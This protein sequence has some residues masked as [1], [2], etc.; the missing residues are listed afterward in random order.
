[1]KKV[2][3]IALI[4]LAISACST[5]EDEPY[6]PCAE[7]YIYSTESDANGFKKDVCSPDP[8][9]PKDCYYT[10]QEVSGGYGYDTYHGPID[11]VYYSCLTGR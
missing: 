7:G 10:T 9:L 3:G 6:N 11:T 1:M 4:S 5:A 2:L 8:S